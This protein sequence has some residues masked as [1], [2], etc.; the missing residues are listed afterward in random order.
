MAV[1]SGRTKA[2][3]RALC[4]SI[5]ELVETDKRDGEAV[6]DHLQVIISTR[7]RNELPPGL[8]YNRFEEAVRDWEEDFPGHGERIVR[9]LAPFYI[10]E[11]FPEPD[12]LPRLGSKVT[13]K[14]R[15]AI[16]WHSF[17][18]FCKIGLT[19][20]IEQECRPADLVALSVRDSLL[21]AMP[22]PADMPWVSRIGGHG[23][24]MYERCRYLGAGD[25]VLEG[26]FEAQ[27]ILV[28]ALLDDDPDDLAT[29]RRFL[30][31]WLTRPLQL[32]A[33]F[34]EDGRLVLVVGDDPSRS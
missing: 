29:M 11:P 8:T 1:N 27:E 34:T 6:A 7:V 12:P 9:E 24:H 4:R 17:D 21:E 5:K 23:P 2:R 25:D 30:N 14:W 22:G 18:G 31:C 10:P 16:S 33:G 13:A 20:W 3:V 28:R 32:P 19:A 15:E 26:F